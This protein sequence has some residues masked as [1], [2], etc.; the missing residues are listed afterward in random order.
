[1]ANLSS[2]A[3]SSAPFHDV[4]FDLCRWD[5]RKL[6]HDGDFR[7]LGHDWNFRE[8]RWQFRQLRH[9]FR[10]VLAGSDITAFAVFP[11]GI[12][13][14]SSGAIEGNHSGRR[15]LV[16]ATAGLWVWQQGGKL[17]A[18]T[19]RIGVLDDGWKGQDGSVLNVYRKFTR[20][21]ANGVGRVTGL[22]G[23]VELGVLWAAELYGTTRTAHEEFSTVLRI[24]NQGP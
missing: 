21:A 8:F 22:N 20:L 16:E 17:H 15:T 10:V 6:R 4:I 18:D 19:D 13:Q 1:M 14:G 9:D 2:G 24:G 7:K 11:V 23:R 5:D 12:E 3:L